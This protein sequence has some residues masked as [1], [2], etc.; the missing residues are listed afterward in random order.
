MAEAPVHKIDEYWPIT[1][2]IWR[3]RNTEGRVWYSVTFE[4][5]FKDAAGNWKSTDGFVGDDLLVLQKV[6]G[7]AHTQVYKFK[8]ADR[9]AAPER[10]PGEEG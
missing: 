2:A 4:R 9:E 7:L 10:E 8:K 3:N 6:A 5:S 1:A